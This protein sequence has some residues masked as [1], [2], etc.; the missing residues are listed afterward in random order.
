MK[1]SMSITLPFS[2]RSMTPNME[3]LANLGDCKGLLITWTRSK[4]SK[5]SRDWK[6]ERKFPRRI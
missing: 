6:W 2:T 4:F 5:R 3:L 1:L